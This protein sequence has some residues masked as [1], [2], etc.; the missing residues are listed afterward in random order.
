LTMG[1]TQLCI[2][3]SN[4]CSGNN[5]LTFRLVHPDN[6]RLSQVSPAQ[7]NID[8]NQYEL[9][10]KDN[11]SYWVDRNIQLNS[12]DVK[13]IKIVMMEQELNSEN[14]KAVE[15]S[16]NEIANNKDLTNPS[17]QG[18]IAVIILNKTGQKKLER[19]TEK[20]LKRK[21]AI[22]LKDKLLMAPLI[23]DKISGNEVSVV[24]LNYYDVKN[25]KEAIRQ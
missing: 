15:V 13:S 9:F 24:G 17:M 5:A 18:F 12:K 7:P 4:A 10:V 14:W 2:L 22:V 21:L 25:L 11:I 8:K 1:S 19:L 23:Q 3:P 20:N 6:D 16:L